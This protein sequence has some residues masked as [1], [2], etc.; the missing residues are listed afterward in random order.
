MVKLP[1]TENNIYDSHNLF[2]VNL[3]LLFGVKDG[4]FLG[5]I[6]RIRLQIR[7]MLIYFAY[8]YESL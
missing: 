3:L 2:I 8:T 1:I 6:D 4:R 5:N 7:L